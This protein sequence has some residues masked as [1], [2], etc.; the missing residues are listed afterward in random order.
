[1]ALLFCAAATIGAWFVSTTA[2]ALGATAA[3]LIVAL[4]FVALKEAS[5]MLA[6][7]SDATLAVAHKSEANTGD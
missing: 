1:M 2:V 7:I 6:D 5:L 4:V 3:L